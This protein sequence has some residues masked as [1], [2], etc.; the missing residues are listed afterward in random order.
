MLSSTAFRTCQVI[1]EP[2]ESLAIMSKDDI[3]D[4]DIHFMLTT[5]HYPC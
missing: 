4:V 2:F 5:H 1:D 3:V